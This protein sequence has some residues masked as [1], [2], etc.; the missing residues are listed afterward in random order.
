MASVVGLFVAGAFLSTPIVRIFRG[1]MRE[2]RGASWT[3]GALMGCT[4]VHRRRCDLGA[5]SCARKFGRSSTETQPRLTFTPDIVNTSRPS[6][7]T[8]SLVA[9]GGPL[10]IRYNTDVHGLVHIPTAVPKASHSRAALHFLAEVSTVSERV[11]ACR[12]EMNRGTF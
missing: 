11:V 1:M 7:R 8:P 4:I 2:L 9:S 3:C 6:L 12:S 5:C 10:T